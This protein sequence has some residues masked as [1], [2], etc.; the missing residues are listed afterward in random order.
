MLLYC[1]VVGFG[2]RGE[3]T[4]LVNLIDQSN[5]VLSK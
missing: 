2:L 3:E 4:V 1:T 5:H